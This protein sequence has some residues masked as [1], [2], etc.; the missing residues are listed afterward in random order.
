MGSNL[1][2]IT[3]KQGT[4]VLGDVTY[5]YDSGR[6]KTRMG[7]SYARTGLPQAL[8]S[9]TY[10]AANQMTQRAST[11]LSY[12]DNGNLTGDGVN[13]FTWDARNR[14]T[15]ISGGTSASFQ[16]DSFGR[17]TSK[18]V[19]SQTTNYLYDR[20]DVV[21]ELSGGT[22][23][24]NML[25]GA[26]VDERHTCDCNGAPRTLLTDALGSTL[27]LTSSSGA[28]ETEYT[29]DPFGATTSSGTA[30][31]N[32]SQYTG[33]ENDSTGLHYYRARYYSP[34]LQRFISEDPIGFGGGDINLYAY[35]GNAPT[36]F[37]DPS[38]NGVIAG[39]GIICLE[40]AILGAAGDAIIN[41]LAGR[42]ITVGGLAR[43]A[44]VGCIAALAGVGFGSAVGVGIRALRGGSNVAKGAGRLPVVPN[45]PYAPNAPIP[46]GP[47]GR[48]APESPYP[49]TQLGTKVSSR[50]GQPYTQGREFAEN[51]VH[52][53]DIHHTNHG[54][55][56]HPN[57]HQHI[58]DPVTGARGRHTPFP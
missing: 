45:R 39:L 3:Y 54:M 34:V 47:H 40:G 42:K 52:V 35:V 6:N 43:S 27:A 11:T 41:T 4:T 20:A 37:K 16:Y 33:R 31:S 8:S 9:A 49:H 17:R 13:T 38:G 12:D 53:R 26:L 51:G 29:Y 30:S 50:T 23:T 25:N 18:T 36:N 15:A 32:A 48:P 58:I 14:L 22:P 19:S 28:V 56:D 24:A 44:G 7:G 2:S 21:Q 46:K 57:P 5:E 55:R 10:N 1:T